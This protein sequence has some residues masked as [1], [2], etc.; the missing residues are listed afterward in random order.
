MEKSGSTCVDPLNS[1]WIIWP[2]L[3]RVRLELQQEPLRVQQEP[4]RVQVLLRPIRLG[5][6]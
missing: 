3:P 1:R 2:E 5:S 6:R 4:P